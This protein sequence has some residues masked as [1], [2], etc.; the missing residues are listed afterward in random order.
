MFKKSYFSPSTNLLY[1]LDRKSFIDNIIITNQI[2][3]TIKVFSDD[4]I[5]DENNAVSIVGPYGSGKSTTA[6]FLYH[7]LV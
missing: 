5:S 6:L 2:V 7:Y 3:Q 4:P 1:D